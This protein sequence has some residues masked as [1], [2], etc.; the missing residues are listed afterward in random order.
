ML[1]ALQLEELG[2]LAALAPV[3]VLLVI[4]SLLLLLLDQGVML[5]HS[6]GLLDLMQLHEF[7]GSEFF[8]RWRLSRLK[9]FGRSLSLCLPTHFNYR[10]IF[11]HNWRLLLGRLAE[12]SWDPI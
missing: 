11:L 10:I 12:Q 1:R 9:E 2:R 6:L 7:R 8:G 5:G 3:L 4:A